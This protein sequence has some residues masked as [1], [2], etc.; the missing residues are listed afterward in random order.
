MTILAVSSPFPFFPDLN[1]EPCNGGRLY[2][3]TAGTN[4][5][6]SPVTVYWDAAGTQPAVQPIMLVNGYTSR[7][8]TPAFVYVSGDF[9]MTLRD[10]KGRIV[11]YAPTSAQ[12]NTGT[13]I[14]TALRADLAN[15]VSTTK[16]PA[17]VGWNPEV[18][19][20][21]DTLG[22][23]QR[24]RGGSVG[25]YGS[26][27][28]TSE[29]TSALAD[30]TYAFVPTGSY[31]PNIA[32]M[33]YW[34]LWGT[35][36]VT[37]ANAVEIREVNP[38]PQTGATVKSYKPQTY[39][40]YENACSM[41]VTANSG[42]GQTRENTQIMGTNSA[43]IALYQDFDHLALHVSASSYTALT[44]AAGTTTYF[45]TGINA[46]EITTSTA[47]IGMWVKTAHGTP[48]VGQIKAVSAG[49]AVV[50]GWF[51]WGT[52]TPGTP[53][54]GFSATINPN[55]KIWGANI[56]VFLPTT[57]DATKGAGVELGLK[58]EKTGSGANTWGYDCITLGGEKP[59]AHFISRGIR[60]T[61]FL[62]QNSGGDFGFL[63]DGQGVGFQSRAPG[64]YS[65]QALISNVSKWA[66]NASGTVSGDYRNVRVVS[67][68]DSVT[69]ADNIMLVTASGGTVTLPTPVSNAGRVFR[70]KALANFTLATAASTID[71]SATKAV[72]SSQSLGVVS[73]GSFWY[74]F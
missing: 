7:N 64:S 38:F 13:T 55:T 37:D 9:S 36:T 72:T 59:A 50:D 15:K 1:G 26:S 42:L 39:G 68:T 60:T 24:N 56:N 21:Y 5:E 23:A 10:R 40:R 73:D 4:P 6:T 61:S 54:N 48:W 22:G 20:P 49:G 17:M 45:S 3:G 46:P 66:V 32:S 16:G 70:F 67:T 25:D 41:S 58:P 65:F 51:E 34:R 11:F 31:T 14:D 71:G 18:N 29:F 27:P 44:T 52:G 28:G 19:Y 33:Q 74:T 12:W 69:D 8:G 43:G 53:A 47:K 30:W 63:S 2:F 62:A 35:G 57:G